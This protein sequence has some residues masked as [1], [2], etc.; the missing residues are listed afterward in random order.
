MDVIYVQ[1]GP[2]GKVKVSR[3]GLGWPGSITEKGTRPVNGVPLWTTPLRIIV[4][5][6]C[7]VV[8][9]ITMISQLVYHALGMV[10]P[11]DRDVRRAGN[12]MICTSTW[13]SIQTTRER[14]CLVVWWKKQANP[15]GMM[16]GKGETRM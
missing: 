1:S 2:S 6:Q 4:V 5:L 14:I 9:K 16:Q 8:V 3:V 13:S 15:Q 10:K 11:S 12:S 7:K